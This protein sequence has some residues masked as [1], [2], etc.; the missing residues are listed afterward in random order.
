MMTTLMDRLD[1][2]GGHPAIKAWRKDPVK[3]VRDQFGVEPDV[4]QI[5]FLIAIRDQNRIAAKACKGPGKTAVLSWAAWWMLTCFPH[6]KIAA[7]SI[8]ADNLRDGL[9]TEMAKWQKKSAFLDAAFQWTATRIY[10]KDHPETWYMVAR[11]WSKAAN[12]EQQANT[13][14]GLHADFMFF[15]IDEA[16]GVPDAVMAAAEAALANAGTTVNPNAIA[17]LLICGN[18]THLSGPLYRA[19][20]SERHLW[21]LIEITGDPDD[22]KRSPRISVQWAREQIQKYG[23]D[24]PWVLVNV[25]GKFPPSSINALLGPDDVS[26]AMRRTVKPEVYQY[27]PK[28]LGVDVARQG[29]DRSVLFPRQGVVAFMPK[30]LR[31]PNGRQVAGHVAQ[32]IQR[33]GPDGV[34]VDATGGYGFAVIEP[35]QEWG[36][37]INEVQ[38]GGE[39]Y[40]KRQFFNRRSEML[41][42]MAQWVKT[43]GCLPNL[44]ELAVELTALTYTF[45][46]DRIF[47][48]PKEQIKEEIGV[49]PDLADGLAL[50]FAV[51]LAKRDPLEQY[52]TKRPYDAMAE[53]YGAINGPANGVDDY[54]PF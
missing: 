53:E 22:P 19:T 20:S 6:A 23:R 4:W 32:A 28:A 7:T 30:I 46:N 41:W 39:A 45:K 12:A 29:D 34:N 54:K 11:A 47:V 25:F 21:Y 52:R 37:V 14:A 16:G 42:N 36:Y 24:N 2:L 17:K 15:I 27:S 18:P 50:T 43:K 49:S 26:A 10:A 38:F 33:W 3:F 31:I 48:I 51:P 8:T 44:P 9:W 40:D 13:L 5:D 1:A 35:L